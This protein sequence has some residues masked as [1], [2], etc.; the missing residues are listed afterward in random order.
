MFSIYLLIKL[1]DLLNVT[2]R[3]QIH[4]FYE[5]VRTFFKFG[6]VLGWWKME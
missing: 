6:D 1:T 2:N 3:V 5:K 4:E